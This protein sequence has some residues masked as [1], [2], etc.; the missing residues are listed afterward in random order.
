MLRSAEY[1][2]FDIGVNVVYQYR[3]IRKFYIPTT[4]RG[5]FFGPDI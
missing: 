4:Y 2:P 1:S 3:N 5:S